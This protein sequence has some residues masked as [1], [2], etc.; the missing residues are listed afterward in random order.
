[1]IRLYRPACAVRAYRCR[2]HAISSIETGP[3]P[4]RSNRLRS[5]YSYVYTPAARALRESQAGGCEGRAVRSPFTR[6][7]EGF[8]FRAGRLFGRCGRSC[9]RDG[10]VGVVVS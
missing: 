6:R 8:R 9:A 10:G 4:L 5:I 1:M 7:A 2:R 3:H